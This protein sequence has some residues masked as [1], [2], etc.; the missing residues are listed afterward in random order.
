[1]RR[2]L[3]RGVEMA[4][5]AATVVVALSCWA[6][7]GAGAGAA[8]PAAKAGA[9]RG[10]AQLAREDIATF[11]L[12]PAATPN[13]IL[14]LMNSTY[15]TVTNMQDFQYFFYRPLYFF[16]EAQKL[17]I[18]GQAS[19]AYP[20]V[21]TDGDRTVTV[22]LKPY[23]WSDGQPVTARDVQFW[24]NLVSANK[25]NWGLY[26]PGLY[27]DN[28]A[29]VTAQ[30]PTT[31]V[32]HLDKAY[33]PTWFTDNELAQITPLPQHVWDKTT[34]G[35][36]VGN[37]D[38]T[39]QGAV[40]VYDFLAAEAK[41]ASSYTTNPLWS[42][43]DGPWKLSQFDAATG[44]SVFVPNRAYSGPV[45]PRLKEFVEEPF[46]TDASEFS[47]LKPANTLS[48]GYL[49]WNDLSQKSALSSAG[50]RFDPWDSFS[51]NYF[52]VNLA[53]G[54]PM[55][56]VFGQTYIRQALEMLVNQ[57][58][59]IADD[60]R[61]YAVPSCGPVP[62]VP[63]NSLASPYERSCP[64]RYNPGRAAALLRSHGWHVV[65]GGSTS[66]AVPA[67]CG[68][69]IS[70]G[71]KLSF[72]LEYPTGITPFTDEIDAYKAALAQAGI[73]ATLKGSTFNT[74]VADAGACLA[75]PQAPCRWDVIAIGGGWVYSPDYYPSGE[76]LFATGAGVNDGQYSNPTMDS[77]IQATTTA[78][79]SAAQSALYSY[80][81]FAVDQVPAIYVPNQAYQL[82]EVAANLKGVVPQN[83]YLNLLPED[84]YYVSS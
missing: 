55:G 35:G 10:L 64:Y 11:A 57:R 48:V 81:R 50:Y 54:S 4:R 16:G 38:E 41:D 63:S 9:S 56:A 73:Q 25:T 2:G 79:G 59:Y 37:Y 78:A 44:R 17:G 67:K 21:Y 22:T 68:P 61:G 71:A 6:A 70:K 83:A 8:V 47:V 62:V 31:V 46:T 30:S 40:A 7:L 26:V 80:E 84:W 60:W 20:P 36:V 45:K 12:Q 65:P 32:F 72:S 52:Y 39:P 15:F 53:K 51:F 74:V 14:P 28:V 27:P 1:M 5:A 58:Q 18:N 24:Q 34:A 3:D 13:Y 43:I 19:L 75:N 69:G 82:S 76:P 33:N 23:T 29:S 77:L 42:V 49:P 66:C